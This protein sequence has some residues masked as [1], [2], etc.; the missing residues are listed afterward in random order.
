MQKAIA[1]H[2]SRFPSLL[3]GQPWALVGLL[4]LGVAAIAVFLMTVYTMTAIE[5]VY[6]LRDPNAVTTSPFYFGSVSTLAAMVW[7]CG[8]TISLFVTFRLWNLERREQ[9]WCLGCPGLLALA[10]GLDDL[11]MIHD[12]LLPWLGLSELYLFP[13]YAGLG[14]MTAFALLRAGYFDDILLLLIGGGTFALS[15]VFDVLAEDANVLTVTVEDTFKLAGIFFWTA[16][17][18]RRSWDA[19]RA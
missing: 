8:A 17:L 18:V 9:A 1:L 4:G 15:L 12:G 14:L 5:A 19:D 13:L 2:L 11:F 16:Y 10:L 3:R 7:I 6:L